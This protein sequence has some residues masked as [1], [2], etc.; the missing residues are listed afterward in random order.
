[1][2]KILVAAY[3]G[4]HA[5]LL[6]PVIRDLKARGYE[7]TVL[8][9]TLGKAVFRQ[10]NLKAL[11]L[12]DIIRHSP[13][14]VEIERVG[15]S[16]LTE[17]DIHP[18]VG[19]NDSLAYLGSGLL[20]LIET[21]DE[22]K[23]LNQYA[24]IGRKAFDQS[25][26]ANEILRITGCDVLVTTSSP[27][28][29]RALVRAATTQN[30]QSIV[31]V[32]LFASIEKA[33]LTNPTFANCICVFH[34]MVK[35]VLVKGGRPARDIIVTG[36]PAFDALSDIPS[37][38]FL[39]DKP[40]IL[41]L[42]QPVTSTGK[43]YESVNLAHVARALGEEVSKGNLTAEIRFHPNEGEARRK[44]VRGDLLDRSTSHS[45]ESTLADADIVVTESSTAGVQAQLLGL[46]L[47]KLGWSARS[48]LVPLEK[49]G[50]TWV[51]QSE[52]QLL[53]QIELAIAAGRFPRNDG[54]GMATSSVVNQIERIARD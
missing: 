11:G 1:M 33:W 42:S 40:H 3:G 32:D 16:V 19:R 15:K 41:L 29:E 46:P 50:P 8:G 6:I 4:G 47:V 45:I 35:Q 54:L 17:Q 44:Q 20:D 28:M 38:R 31:V 14:W 30:K 26:T 9:L 43:A 34:E 13:R 25:I 51:V 27:R 48:A 7:I 53:A 10:A 52:G 2:S 5:R 37:K 39:R 21:Q 49:L 23:A 22:A 24:T 36:N 18:Q 12:Y